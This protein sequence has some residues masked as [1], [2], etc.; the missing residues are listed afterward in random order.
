MNPVRV[1][2]EDAYS[3]GGERRDD[4]C[5]H[6]LSRSVEVKK[7]PYLPVELESKSDDKQRTKSGIIIAR[8]ISMS[9]KLHFIFVP[10][11]FNHPIIYKRMSAFYP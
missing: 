1:K 7:A 11:Y 8:R 9:F 10:T 2:N 4:T 5:D 6:G 3:T